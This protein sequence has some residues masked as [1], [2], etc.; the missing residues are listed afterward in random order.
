[1]AE[2]YPVFAYELSGQYKIK[3]Q[4]DRAES[5]FIK[6]GELVE[7]VPKELTDWIQPR[8]SDDLLKGLESYILVISKKINRKTF[9]D[10]SKKLSI[11]PKNETEEID[12]LIDDYIERLKAITNIG[13]I[14]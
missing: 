10:V 9:S 12:K 4:L 8:L 5:Y 11:K 3:D 6:L 2:V 1:L 7:E 14:R 13:L